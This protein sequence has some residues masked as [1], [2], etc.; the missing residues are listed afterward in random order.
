MVE[1]RL[2]RVLAV[3][4]VVAVAL[5]RVVVGVHWP[6]DVVG[7]SLLGLGLAAG[8]ALIASRPSPPPRPP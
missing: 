8:A 4:I 7:S 5:A 3:V 2:V 1:V 6:A